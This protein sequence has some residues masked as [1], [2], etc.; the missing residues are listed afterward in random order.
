[1]DLADRVLGRRNASAGVRELSVAARCAHTRHRDQH[2]TAG[3]RALNDR[4]DGK[5]AVRDPGAD[6]NRFVL[7]W[8]SRQ[9][10]EEYKSQAAGRANQAALPSQQRTGPLLRRQGR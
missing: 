6:L 7:A 5:L 3:Q 10:V 4:V 9:A 1:M 8:A 2:V